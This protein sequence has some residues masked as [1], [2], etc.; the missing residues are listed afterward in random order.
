MKRSFSPRR[1]GGNRRDDYDS[2]YNRRQD[3]DEE[4]NDREYRR[5]GE[6]D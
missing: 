6:R 2:D 4:F 3:E 5:G 1:N